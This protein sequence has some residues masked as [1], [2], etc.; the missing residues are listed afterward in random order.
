[1]P[2]S[3]IYLHV[4]WHQHQ[5]WYFKPDSN[6]AVMPWV[7]LHGVK[8]YYDIAWLSKEYEGWKQ[9]INLVPSLLEQLELYTEHQATDVYL[10]LSRKPAD[11]LTHEEKTKALEFFFHA[12][13]QRMIQPFPRYEELYRKRG[14][15]VQQAAKHFNIQDLLD[16]QVWY[17]IAWLD[18]LWRNNPALPVADLISKQRNFSEEEKHLIL[19]LQQEILK[20]IIP[21]HRDLYKQGK[22]DLTCTSYFHPILPL[23][24]DSNIA[25]ISNPHD[26]VP[27][28]AFRHP[29]DAEMQIRQGIQKF[30]EIMRIAPKGMWPS[31]GSVSDEALALIAG[32]GIE[33]AATDENILFRSQMIRGGSS[34]DRNDLYRLH[35]WVGSQGELDM[36]FRDRGL[37]D[38][39]GF[40]Y[41][42]MEAK[43]AARNFIQH[44]KNVGQDWTDKTCPPLVNVILDGE[45]CWEFYPNDGHDF[46]RYFIEGI[47]GDPQI[48]STTL[49]EFRERYPSEP[50]LKSI[51]PGSWI[52]NNFR[53]W[54]GHKED[55]AAWHFLRQARE[56]LVE[57]EKELTPEVREQAWREMF[58]CEGSDWFWWYGDDNYTEL[59]WLF[60]FL[61][62]EHLSYLYILIGHPIP[63]AL[64]RPIKQPKPIAESGGGILF[65]PPRIC[66]DDQGYYEWVGA[67]KLQL[68]SEGGAMHIA[69]DIK[70]D[71]YYGRF[72]GHLCFSIQFQDKRILDETEKIFLHITKPEHHTLEMTSSV[73]GTDMK[74]KG[75]QIEGEVDLD[76][77]GIEPHQE[78]WFFFHW[79]SA[80]HTSFS[81][82]VGS[83]L[84]LQ[85]YTLANASLYWFI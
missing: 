6:L 2:A 53:I 83:E 14:S 54:I 31:E 3:E 79:E 48:L 18:P 10:D 80:N 81:I 74:R 64:Q 56:A 35:R 41:Q 4:L 13:H 73:E 9:T 67:R 39:I 12:N 60:D 45:N 22:I 58:I 68:G 15:S 32:A 5:P 30:T 71:L 69:Y 34:T 52:N 85:G 42:K 24:C 84:Y 20:K 19:D 50:T 25:Q 1:M 78:I 7:R 11:Q 72:D 59:D 17:N 28:P 49:P 77:L 47:L 16:L 55:N 29:E 66:G 27:K 61:F 70:G 65:K 37:S 44:I 76:L 8:D 51:Y 82:P 38:L 36:V 46:L 43:E 40:T 33:Y 23:L 62:R 63:D 21:L 57:V 26:P 75:N